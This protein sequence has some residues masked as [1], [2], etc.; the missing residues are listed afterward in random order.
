MR[1]Q[2]TFCVCCKKTISE[3]YTCSECKVLKR[4]RKYCNICG[5]RLDREGYL[6]MKCKIKREETKKGQLIDHIL[7]KHEKKNPQCVFCKWGGKCTN[8]KMVLYGTT[9]RCGF[10]PRT[11]CKYFKMKY[12]E[13]QK[14]IEKQREIGFFKR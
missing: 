13:I 9:F 2:G 8:R 10:K 7:I 11:K 6:C 3:T 14:F 5:K 4:K 12:P 1:I